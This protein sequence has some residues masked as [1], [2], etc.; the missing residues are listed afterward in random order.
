MI[1]KYYKNYN[2]WNFVCH[3][4]F[5]IESNEDGFSLG[6]LNAANDYYYWDDSLKKFK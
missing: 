5:P 6:A 4:S 1:K 3:F 2:P